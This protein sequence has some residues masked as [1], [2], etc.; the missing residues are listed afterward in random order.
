[1]IVGLQSSE[2]GDGFDSPKSNSANLSYNALC[3]RGG[4]PQQSGRDLCGSFFLG[5][6]ANRGENDT[7]WNYDIMHT[8]MADERMIER[9][10]VFVASCCLYHH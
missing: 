10:T 3:S 8:R 5:Q 4:L 7:S 6:R 1:M 9:C 2:A